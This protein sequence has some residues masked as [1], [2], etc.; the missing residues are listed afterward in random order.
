MTSIHKYSGINGHISYIIYLDIFHDFINFACR[1]THE[2]SFILRRATYGMQNT[3]E[4]GHSCLIVTTHEMSFILP[5]QSVM[6]QSVTSLE[7]LEEQKRV[8]VCRHKRTTAAAWQWIRNSWTPSKSGLRQGK[9]R[10]FPRGRS[11]TFR[12]A[13]G[14]EK[15]PST[16]A[17]NVTLARTNAQRQLLEAMDSKQLNTIYIRAQAKQKPI[18]PQGPKWHLWN[19]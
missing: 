4:L 14:K 7:R 16:L 13:K 2:M 6:E 9:N 3:M 18:I 12:N 19:P 11:G 1:A 8:P 15:S 10:T 17:K 5:E